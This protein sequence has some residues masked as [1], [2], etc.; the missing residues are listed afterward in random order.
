M[1]LWEL[2]DFDIEQIYLHDCAALTSYPLKKGRCP[3]QLIQA[4]DLTSEHIGKISRG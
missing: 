2:M 1:Q 4:V 3:E